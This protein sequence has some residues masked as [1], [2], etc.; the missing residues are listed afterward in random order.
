[1]LM[2]RLFLDRNFFSAL[3]LFCS[4]QIRNWP[5]W[6]LAALGCAGTH[7]LPAQSTTAQRPESVHFERG[8]HLFNT[9]NL[10]AA[11]QQFEAVLHTAPPD[12]LLLPE[13]RYLMAVCAVRLFHADGEKQL[14]TFIEQH[15][16]H[17]QAVLAHADL[18]NFFYGE[19]QFEKAAAQYGKVRL[20]ALSADRQIET[21]FKWG[22]ALFNTKAWDEAIRQFDLVKNM[23]GQ[24]A[25]AAGYYAG[26]IR[27]QQQDYAGALTDFRRAEAHQAYAQ[28]VQPLIASSLYYNRQYDAVIEYAAQ[29]TARGSLANSREMNLYVG[30]AHYKRKE[31]T[32]ALEA[33]RQ[34]LQSQTKPDPAVAYRA[35]A[36]ADAAGQPAL[37]IEYLKSAALAPDTLGAYA[38][39][40]LGQ[41]YLKTDQKP[42]ALAA[43]EVA[44][45]GAADATT[46]E[47]SA[48]LAAKLLYD[49]G[50]TDEAIARLEQFLAQHPRSA[51]S[52]E[53]REILSQAYVNAN[54][55]NKAIEYIEALPRRGPAIDQ[56]YQR[57][58]YLRG[59][60]L[61]NQELYPEAIR[62]F[63]LSL[64]YPIKKSTEAEAAYWCGEAFSI[65]RKY[66]EAV[67]LYQRA[68]AVSADPRLTANI[69]YALGYALF[70]Q[71]E[72]S[73]AA[74]YFSRFLAG[75][76]DSRMA[77]ARLRWAD[78][79]FI[80]KN[81]TEALAGYRQAINQKTA[82]ADYAMLQIAVILGIQRRYSEALAELDGLISRFPQSRHRDEARFTRAQ[83]NF[84]RG[85]YA[86][87]VADYSLLI[88]LPAPGRFEPYALM[89]RAASFFNLK[90]YNRTADDYI[91]MLHRYP[92]H[93]A[94]QDIMVHLQEALTLANRSDEFD[95]HL[96]AFKQANPDARGIE[97]VEFEALKGVF[98]GQ[99]YPQTV[100]AV[101]RFLASYPESARATEA[102]YY[103]AESHYRLHNYIE[104]LTLFREV[105]AD[106]SFPLLNR[107]YA[108]MGELEAQAANWAGAIRS[109]KKLEQA[110]ANKRD[111]YIA[112]SAL[113]EIHHR[114]GRY[115]S[116]THY[117]GLVQER[118]NVN[119][120]AANK[121]ALY[122]GKALMGQG[123]YD[124]A[125]DEFIQTINAAQDEHG[126]EAKYLLAEIYFLSKEHKR[127]FETLIDF[128][129]MYPAYTEWVGKAFLLLAE[130]FLATNEVFQARATLQSLV[131]GFPLETI[132]D[133]A[134]QRLLKLN[135]NPASVSDT[136]NKR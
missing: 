55:F 34:H 27:F 98:F 21:R 80:G 30:E 14:E 35:G 97:S 19:R 86:A 93:P 25:P 99:R 33:Y 87:A 94:S 67:P 70:N 136:T 71:Q 58:T 124:E 123:R 48:F 11:R 2:C 73:R 105:A 57:A 54:N 60:D 135:A 102:R 128:N 69:Q 15:P 37:A 134:R 3:L 17:P 120:G 119:A 16:Q 23:G 43:F 113:M 65:G 108:R 116:V 101:Q 41:V 24:Y 121:A 6:V 5:A 77:D 8:L 83:L 96:A 49:V 9:G 126:A 114:L 47:E 104:A 62:Y 56:A 52:Q 88:D 95:Q 109:Y 130:N 100:Q 53:V 40:R 110:A 13:A 50:R 122:K 31:Y 63:Q 78:C 18:G 26:F 1:M 115:D 32:K 90:E 10:S 85:Q 82:D 68:L 74:T 92:V 117:A 72:Y 127:C 20:S 103:L 84:E 125:K 107:V 106:P 76:A 51:R 28:V 39:F 66:A 81:Y 79:Q 22:Y 91:R 132:K 4:V 12:A 118:A 45:K 133:K 89:R 7:L 44:A 64:E 29:L 59:A 111:L 129:A 46:R 112:W 61:F 36:S 42:L 38:S 75:G 131:D